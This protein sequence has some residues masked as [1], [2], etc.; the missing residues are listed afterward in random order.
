MLKPFFHSNVPTIKCQPHVLKCYQALA[1]ILVT[2]CLA[3]SAT[4]CEFKDKRI[5]T[6]D[7]QIKEFTNGHA[8]SYRELS[9]SSLAIPSE[10]EW[11][12]GAND[13]V[14]LGD[15][16]LFG[17]D[18][19]LF[20]IALEC[21]HSWQNHT[22]KLIESV[23]PLDHR[24]LSNIEIFQ[25]YGH[26]MDSAATELYHSQEL[27]ADTFAVHVLHKYG[28]DPITAMRNILLVPFS[29]KTHPARSVRMAN[30][31]KVLASLKTT[32]STAY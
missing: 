18:E 5:C 1:S 31:R 29:T 10:T 8:V 19:L 3:G 2:L 15:T 24:A 13:I 32:S 17:D 22:R 26:L 16:A 25:K 12:I 11:V 9:T 27:E 23:T 30:A 7:S 21:S 28:K 14:H 6:I 4:A 20:L